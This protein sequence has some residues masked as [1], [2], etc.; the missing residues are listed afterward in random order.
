MFTATLVERL[1]PQ[2]S[3]L[4]FKNVKERVIE[5]GESEKCLMCK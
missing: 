3:T 2:S 5:F 1:K 4:T